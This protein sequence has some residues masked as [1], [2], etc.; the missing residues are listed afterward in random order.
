MT[1]RLILKSLDS[2]FQQDYTNFEVIVVNDG[3]TDNTLEVL[4]S[5]TDSRLKILNITNSERA[6][7]RNRGVEIAKGDYVTFLDSDDKYYSNY[8][9]NA[10]T[11]LLNKSRP[12]FYHQAYCNAYRMFNCP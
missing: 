8:L 9:S 4:R 5:I 1:G 7:A 12:V 10:N 6:A 11:V 3:S 2:V